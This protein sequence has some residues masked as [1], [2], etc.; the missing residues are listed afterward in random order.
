LADN[1][2]NWRRH[3]AGQAEGLDAVLDEVGWAGAALYNEA[4][5]RLIDGHLRKKRAIERGERVPVL[6]GS[7]TE[8]Q[9]RLILSTL[10]PLAAMAEVAGQSLKD[11]IDVVEPDAPEGTEEIFE[12]LKAEAEEA[13]AAMVAEDAPDDPGAQVDKAEELREKWGV[14]AGQLWQLGEHRLICGD[15]T[16]EAVV[17]RVM[18]GE[19]AQLSHHDPPYGAD[20]VKV[21]GRSNRGSI[22]GRN[23]GPVGE[24]EPVVGDDEPFDPAHLMDTGDVVVLWGANYYADKLAPSSCWLVWD[25]RDGMASNNFADCELAWVSSPSPARIFAHR[26]MGMMKASEHGEKRMHPTQ[27]PVA[28]FEW[29]V[30]LFTDEAGVVSDWYCGAGGQVLAC[31]RL[32]RRCRAVEIAPKYVAVT[33]ERWADMTD[34]EPVLVESQTPVAADAPDQ[35][36]N[37]SRGTEG[38]VEVTEDEAEGNHQDAGN[39]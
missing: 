30:S 33:L 34:E 35:H 28:L 26:W 12:R 7:W 38:G 21:K 27:K 9:E 20:V 8:E 24:Y 23:W 32:N 15:C 25:K 22:G 17:E 29:V 3:P 14:E 11:L 1:P 18:D 2:E 13:L 4:T 6:V 5:G 31:E 16:D 37:A 19:K 39:D 10:D 36:S